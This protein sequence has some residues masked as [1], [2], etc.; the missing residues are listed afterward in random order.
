MGGLYETLK[1]QQKLLL[2]AFRGSELS[3]VCKAMPY[4]CPGELVRAHVHLTDV[5]KRLFVW[6]SHWYVRC[7]LVAGSS[8]HRR[9]GDIMGSYHAHRASIPLVRMTTLGR[10]DNVMLCLFIFHFISL[11]LNFLS[12]LFHF[13]SIFQLF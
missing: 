3:L 6:F 10:H 2:L 7:L 12:F 9:W 13:I 4:W 1:K 11:H 8:R 5:W